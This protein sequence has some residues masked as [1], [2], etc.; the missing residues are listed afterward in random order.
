LLDRER[1][2]EEEGSERQSDRRQTYRQTYHNVEIP[3]SKVRV[4]PICRYWTYE[5]WIQ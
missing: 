4:G 2:K 3:K 1:E 5:R